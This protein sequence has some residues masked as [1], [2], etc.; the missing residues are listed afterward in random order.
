[1]LPVY[2]AISFKGIIQKGGRT[3]PWI[4]LVQTNNGL[5]PYVVKLFEPGLINYKDSVANEVLGNVLASEFNL[6]VPKAAL[7]DMDDDFIDSIRNF[8][9]IDVL[10]ST[11]TR[12]KF[13][14]EL[15]EGAFQ[16]N[17]TTFDISE[18]KKLVEID[19]VFAFDNLI[20]N[21]DRNRGRSNILIKRPTSYLID[22]EM[23][24]EITDK[25]FDET[26]NYRWDTKFYSQH[27]F[28][29]Y[30]KDS[31]L[32]HKKEYF[33]EFE[34]CLRTL[35]VK[36]LMPYY[37]QLTELGY[38]GAKHPLI[39]DYLVKMKENSTNFVNILRAAIS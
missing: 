25:S 24:F 5:E 4:V 34:E 7:I 9:A 19:T 32:R 10:H 14:S 8:E 29:D 17:H 38:S 37:S 20:R 39:T 3:K 26:Y 35:N 16:F 33:G 21:S 15:L 6:S 1:L 2:K 23:S 28:I 12:I 22:H 11:D 27:I 30:L 13:G 18:I 36:R 31:I